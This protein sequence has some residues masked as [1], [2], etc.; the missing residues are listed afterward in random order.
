MTMRRVDGF[1]LI[2][3]AR[4]LRFEFDG[5]GYQGFEGDTVASALVACGVRVLGRSFKYHRPRG[6]WGAWSDD[7]NA[8]MNISRAGR[9][10]PNCLASTTYLEEGMSARAVNAWPSA[11]QIGRASCRER[12]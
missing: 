6:L 7:P 5:H 9:E 10:L 3:R 1:G 2:D 8:I 11:A 4:P 12:V